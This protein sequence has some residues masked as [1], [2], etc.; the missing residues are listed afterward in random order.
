MKLLSLV[1]G[2]LGLLALLLA[3]FGR[4]FG[5]SIVFFLGDSFSSATMLQLSCVGFSMGVF[6]R[7]LAMKQ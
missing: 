3:L 7:L 5:P 1:L 2:A 6:V 4:F